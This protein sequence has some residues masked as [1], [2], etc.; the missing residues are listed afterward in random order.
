MP[1]EGVE[2]KPDCWYGYNCRTQAHK[3]S[4]AEKLNVRLI[5]EPLFTGATFIH[6]LPSIYASQLAVTV[7]LLRT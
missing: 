2:F 1:T 5:I 3:A 6:A 7:V 4:H